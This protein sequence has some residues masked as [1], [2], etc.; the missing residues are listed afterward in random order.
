MVKFLRVLWNAAGDFRRHGCTTLAASLAY[1][2]LLSL[3]PLAFMLLYLVSFVVSRD[4]IGYDYLL[5]FMQSFLPVLGGDLA[6]GIKRIAEQ[7]NLQWFSIAA[8]TWFG[9][10]VFQEVQYAVNVVFGTARQR[11]PLISTA[12]SAGLLGLL[13]VFMVLSYLI[14]QVLGIVVAYTP[15]IGGLDIVAVR[16]NR[17]LLSVLVP[18]LLT[19]TAAAGLYRFLPAKHPAWRSAF[20]GGFVLALL[21]EGAKHLFTSYLNTLS[22]YS[23]MYGSMVAVILFLLWVYYSAALFLYGAA[24]VKRLTDR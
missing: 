22:L 11:N 12:L 23:R 7:R 9:L 6:R 19:W 8:F 20:A 14:T 10:L 13:A 5:H 1:F 21:W 16:A 4:H 3:F 18:F 2:S 15:S 17:I 24:I